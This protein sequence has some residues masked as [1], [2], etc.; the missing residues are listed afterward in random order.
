MPPTAKR[1]F[2][3][4]AMAFA[5]AT[6][7]SLSSPLCLGA[8]G[9]LNSLGEQLEPESVLQSD[10]E[11]LKAQSPFLRTLNPSESLVLVGLAQIDGELVATLRERETKKTHIVTAAGNEEGWRIVGVEGDLSD[12]GS[13]EAQ[14]SVADE[15]YA[16][17]YDQQQISQPSQPNWRRTIKLSER[18]QKYV[19]YQAQNFRRG[20]HGD[21]Y[22]GPTPPELAD[23]LSR[24]S[25][26]QR[27]EII[28]RLTDMTNRG[29]SNE[30][31]QKAVQQMTDRALNAN[32]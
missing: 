6:T 24:L 10:F 25:Q 21:G 23:K 9:T 22:R 26:G 15:I 32:R 5:V 13:V 3:P 4:L 19:V 31:R 18:Q 29:I 20:I 1:D 17:R 2:Y 16:I 11:T 8:E 14:I 7:I 27:E 30:D 12:L 28:A